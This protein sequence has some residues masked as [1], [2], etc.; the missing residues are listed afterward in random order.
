MLFSFSTLSSGRSRPLPPPPPRREESLLL[1]LWASAPF[2]GGM[3]FM[4]LVVLV[5]CAWTAGPPPID[6]RCTLPW[7]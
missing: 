7:C 4:A 3:V 2:Q 1:N 6:D 5:A